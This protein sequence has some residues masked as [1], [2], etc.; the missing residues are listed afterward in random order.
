LEAYAVSSHPARGL[1]GEG[2]FLVENRPKPLADPGGA[3]R[4][5][6]N[7]LWYGLSL[8]RSAIRYGAQVAVFDSGTTHWF[9]LAPLA[10][11][12]VQ[13]VPC[14]HNTLWPN[15]SVPAGLVKRAIRTLDGWFWKAA[16][17]T[18][19]VSPECQRQVE[20]VSPTRRSPIFQFRGQYKPETFAAVNPP[21][22]HDQAPFRVLYVGRVVRDK[23]VFDLL[24]IAQ[25]LRSDAPNRFAFEVCGAGPDLDGLRAAA[26]KRGLHELI[27]VFG[28]V[29]REDL[30]AAYGRCHVVIVPTR[31]PFCE[32][33]PATA[34]EA[35][36]A[37][38][39]VVT[40]RLSNVV[41]VFEGA[42]VEA[43][44]DDPD[45]YVDGLLRLLN[46]REYY[47]GCCGS[48]TAHRGQFYDRDQSWGAA[49][50]RACR[51]FDAT[52]LARLPS[53]QV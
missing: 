14:L 39:P 52:L 11:A 19:C 37:G 31:S 35:I 48:A 30:L 40:S 2:P 23:G 20:A 13:V 42:V 32:G 49:M 24:E 22:S 38:R 41:D 47:L 8:V 29:S 34:A 51:S 7:Q 12:G 10:L 33:L 43:R 17:A 46:D 1:I 16:A 15:G 36:L 3:L 28:W 21:P 18:L 4:Y 26:N 9:A 53:H 27:Q 45:S 6:V 5:H 44:P 50:E 25:R